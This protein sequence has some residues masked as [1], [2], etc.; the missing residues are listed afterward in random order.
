MEQEGSITVGTLLLLFAGNTQAEQAGATIGRQPDSQ[1]FNHHHIP[2]LQLPPGHASRGGCL[3]RECHLLDVWQ[4]PCPELVRR[5]RHSSLS[6][7]QQQPI[8]PPKLCKC[9]LAHSSAIFLLHMHPVL[10]QTGVPKRC[11]TPDGVSVSTLPNTD[12]ISH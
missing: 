3:T 5:A 12:P 2:D 1:L 7:A 8:L 6:G 11:L 10:S 4:A 9:F